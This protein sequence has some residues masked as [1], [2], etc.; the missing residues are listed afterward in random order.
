MVK[1]TAVELL[2]NILI[3]YVVVNWDNAQ[4]NDVDIE[5]VRKKPKHVDNFKSKKK[6]TTQHEW[7]K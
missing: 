2:G 6:Q 5:F 1:Y 7:D 3:M 4:M